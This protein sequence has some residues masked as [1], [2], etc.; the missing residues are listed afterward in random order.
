MPNASCPASNETRL[1][2]VLPVPICE[3]FPE[4]K[5]NE[6]KKWLALIKSIISF[7]TKTQKY[8]AHAFLA[9]FGLHI[10]TVV[11][12]GLGLSAASSQEY[13]EMTRNVYLA[14]LFE[15]PFVYGAAAVHVFSGVLERILRLITSSKKQVFSE[16]TLIIKDVRRDDIGLG[17]LGSIFGFGFKKSW[18]SSTVPALTPLTFSGYVLSIVL[19]YHTWKMKWAPTLVD[20]GSSLITMRYVTHYLSPSLNGRIV[21]VFN[22]S[23]LALLLWVSFYHIVSGLFKYRRQFS[24][25]AKKM[26]YVV[27]TV[28]TTLSFISIGRL[29]RWPVETGF[30]GAQFNKYL[31]K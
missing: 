14:P 8:S 21:A 16:R 10:S 11:L 5:H 3:P 1:Q 28:F 6:P 15:V 13:F 31:L 19:A 26:A 25:R 20:G 12:P 2:L 22:Y 18:I 30:M 29:S 27:I 9:F 23:M 4:E 17:G 24:S 7:L